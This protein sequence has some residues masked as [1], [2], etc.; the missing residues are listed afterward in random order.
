VVQGEEDKTKVAPMIP[1][2]EASKFIHKLSHDVTGITHNI[3]GYATLLEEENNPDYLAG[4]SRLITKLNERMK[5]AVT[6]VDEG[7]L[8]EKS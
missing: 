3:M 8:I 5:S 2:E 7:D 6:E 4:I 1:M